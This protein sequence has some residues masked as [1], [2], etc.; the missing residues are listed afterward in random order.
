M[1]KII[2]V[3]TLG[4]IFLIGC[5]KDE[6]NRLKLENANLRAEKTGLEAR[7]KQIVAERDSIQVKYEM[8]KE[9]V[10]DKTEPALS[11]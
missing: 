3:L 9:I 2:L 6:L 8:I 5:S 1:K 11:E 10:Q 7:M 4:T